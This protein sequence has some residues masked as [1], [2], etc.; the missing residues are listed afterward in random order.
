MLSY[1][2]PILFPDEC[3]VLEVSPGRYVYNI[4]LNGS[5]SLRESGF[6]SL[7]MEEIK[8]LKHV[9][10]F[11]REPFER[12]VGGVQK[13]LLD[14]DAEYN[15]NT[16]LLMIDE[17]IFLNRHFSLQFHWLVNLRR[18]CDPDITIRPLNALSEVT[19]ETRHIMDRDY[20]LV[21]R[22]KQN[23]RIAYYLQLDKVLTQDLL[24]KTVKF[25]HIV[26]CIKQQYPDL[27]TDVIQRSQSIC[28]VLD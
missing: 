19:T 2:D 17:F 21:N 1:I 12:Y 18:Y 16:V 11:V 5:S 25:S 24:D 9:E 22:F 28:S 27:Y 20:T 26:E 7:S 3:E 10:I 15:H 8:N 14:L 23:Q 4:F 13:Y 6:R